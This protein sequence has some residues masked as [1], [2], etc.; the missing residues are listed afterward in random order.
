MKTK[1]FKMS[2][3]ILMTLFMVG[4]VDAQ[5]GGFRMIDSIPGITKEQKIKVATMRETHRIEMSELRDK[6]NASSS[7]E[8]KDKIDR[9]M[10]E[11]RIEFRNSLRNVFND[12]Q[13]KYFDQ[14]FQKRFGKGMRCNEKGKGDCNRQ[15][16]R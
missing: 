13:K 7:W 11:K 9:Q 15:C 4:Q 12:E 14:N 2:L 5:R 3:A 10:L 6:R 16:K 1:L 8:E